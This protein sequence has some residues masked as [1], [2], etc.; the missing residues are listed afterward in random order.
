MLTIIFQVVVLI[1]CVPE[2]CRIGKSRTLV[3][4]VLSFVLIPILFLVIAPVWPLLAD[5][6][7]AEG[8]DAFARVFLMVV[9]VGVAA[10]MA[11]ST[12]RDIFNQ[13][14]RVAEIEAGLETMLTESKIRLL[15]VD[16]LQRQPDNYILVRRQELPEEAFVPAADTR[17]LLRA[18]KIA[19][20]SYRWLTAAH[21]DPEGFHMRA[22]RSYFKQARRGAR[23]WSPGRM[24][25]A[26]GIF[27]DFAS[28]FQ[29]ERTEE[30]A[31]IFRSSMDVMTR[32]Y[33]SPN[34]L[35]LQH[36]RMP[37]S[38]VCT[39]PADPNGQASYDYSGW[40]NAEQAAASLATEGGGSLFELGVGRVRLS[41]SRRKSPEEMKALFADERRTRF[42]GKADRESV[43]ESYAAFH[44]Q[45]AAFDSATVPFQTRCNEGCVQ[46][47]LKLWR[48]S[49][50]GKL[51]IGW[52]ACMMLA[53][54]SFGVAQG[55]GDAA[56]RL[57]ILFLGII[58]MCFFPFMCC[59]ASPPFRAALG[60]KFVRQRGNT[61][62]QIAPAPA[63]RAAGGGARQNYAYTG[64]V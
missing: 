55:G 38:V 42:L 4:L 2:L 18:R 52:L 50:L 41:A 24:R 34:T 54:P 13:R 10:V 37:P 12:V 8:S 36:K 6:L 20:L 17:S 31:A 32:L 21:P 53:S 61:K 26:R 62:L 44:A 63:E 49:I 25:D 11:A 33:A 27:W 43:G 58:A 47:F 40:C 15:S 59:G 16:W 35:V 23:C 60:K 51:F 7:A 9:C 57:L 28:C 5:Y 48:S 14:K 56:A 22:V 29:K 39:F 3:W 46:A 64:E 45:I 30:Q 1:T 19:V